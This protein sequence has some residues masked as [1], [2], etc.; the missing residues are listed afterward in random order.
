MIVD[1]SEE[2]LHTEEIVRSVF[3]DCVVIIVDEILVA[4]RYIE[5]GIIDLALVEIK[6]KGE[7]GYRIIKMIKTFSPKTNVAVLSN[8]RFGLD[9]SLALALGAD[10]VFVKSIQPNN[11]KDLKGYLKRL[12]SGEHANV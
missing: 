5:T 1:S 7:S 3:E 6:L 11:S 9:C 10:D 4:K 8:S 2:S 12:G